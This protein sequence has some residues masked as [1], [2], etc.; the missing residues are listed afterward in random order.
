MGSALRRAQHTIR[1]TC[2]C[3]GSVRRWSCV[4]SNSL[5]LG[6]G[7]A[8]GIAICSPVSGMG[9]SEPAMDGQTTR[10]CRFRPRPARFAG[11][12]TSLKVGVQAKPRGRLHSCATMAW[13]TPDQAMQ[14]PCTR[15]VISQRLV[16]SQTAD[17]RAIVP[18]RHM[19]MKCHSVQT[20]EGSCKSWPRFTG[21]LRGRSGC[22]SSWE[23]GN[24]SVP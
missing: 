23:A 21:Q 1:E 13:R 19:L 14:P 20:P 9:I 8:R 4:G 10:S 16:N 18:R 24:L 17:Y 12:R 2:R 7:Q 22:T 15:L 11:P 3:G 5:R 6:V